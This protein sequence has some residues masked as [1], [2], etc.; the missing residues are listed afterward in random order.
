MRR[1]LRHYTDLTV[2]Q[3]RLYSL[4]TVITLC[5]LLLYCLGITSFL[6]RLQLVTP[7]PLDNPAT[8]A[9]GPT[10]SP[11]GSAAPG[12]SS[13]PTP[14][15]PPTPTQRPIPTATP[16]SL[17]TPASN[18]ITMTVVVTSTAGLTTTVVI[19]ATVTPTPVVS[20]TVAVT[21]EASLRSEPHRQPELD[22]AAQGGTADETADV[23]T[24]LHMVSCQAT[25]LGSGA[26]R[27]PGGAAALTLGL[28]SIPRR[29]CLKGGKAESQSETLP[30]HL[31]SFE[32]S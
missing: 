3:K 26:M 27:L 24:G 16:T 25:D 32:R 12:Q 23:R 8:V 30:L 13:T 28:S 31:D 21:S 9:P 20:G 4:L 7:A 11:T 1:F 2:T 22:G 29:R 6:L 10:L 19:S 5:A 18:T 17:A 15:L 14:T